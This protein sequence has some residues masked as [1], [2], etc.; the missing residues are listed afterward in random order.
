MYFTLCYISIIVKIN[1]LIICFQII[2][3]LNLYTPADEYEE[4]V[5]VS[6][7]R[8]MQACLLKRDEEQANLGQNLTTGPS[9]LLMDTKYAF[10]I[11]FPF[12]PSN[13][14]LEDIVIPECLDLDHVLRKV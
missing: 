5:P 3:I 14:Q 13:I 1:Q 4:R 8:K 9:T 2:K 7:I 11:R 6:F 10:P 12:N